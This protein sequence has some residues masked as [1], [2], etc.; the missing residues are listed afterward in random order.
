MSK[1]IKNNKTNIGMRGDLGAWN[2]VIFLTLALILLVIVVT[3]LNT[4][5]SD[6]RAKAGLVCPTVS[7]PNPEACPSGWKYISNL[8]GCPGFSCETK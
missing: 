8:N 1:K 6:L 5:S 2:F 4:A 7:L 3:Q